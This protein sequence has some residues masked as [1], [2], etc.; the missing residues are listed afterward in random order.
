MPWPTRMEKATAE[1]AAVL[2]AGVRVLVYSGQYDLICNHLGTE[3][4]LRELQWSG[5]ARRQEAHPG[6]WQV[7]H[8]PAGYSRQYR[9]L[10][11]LVILNAGHM[12]PMDQQGGPGDVQGLPRG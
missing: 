5:N 3:T 9:N 6:V 10:Q 7:N 4:V 8:Q 12:V 1:L 2:D 11:S